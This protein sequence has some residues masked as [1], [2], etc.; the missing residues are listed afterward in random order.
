MGGADPGRL[1]VGETLSRRTELAHSGIA[2]GSA[3]T[4]TLGYNDRNELTGS[5]R[6]DSGVYARNY[7]YD[8]IG[9]R[10]A[11][12]MYDPGV[13]SAY[14]RNALNQYYRVETDSGSSFFAQAYHYDDDGNLTEAAVAADM[15]CDGTINVSDVDAYTLALT[16]PAQYAAISRVQPTERRH[17]RRRRAEHFRHRAVRGLSDRPFGRHRHALRL[18]LGRREPAGV[19]R[20]GPA[21]EA[22]RLHA[23]ERH[24]RC[25]TQ[26]LQKRRTDW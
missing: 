20:P 21:R 5:T 1:N 7:T 12:S 15:N 16:Q 9:N 11:S 4:Q 10:S 13:P 6:S 19:H 18:P 24:R 2:F 14:F 23:P 17:Q 8:A 3:F 26:P 22:G 25:G